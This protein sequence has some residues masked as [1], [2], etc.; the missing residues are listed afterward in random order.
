MT[1]PASPDRQ[2]GV[3]LAYR[4]GLSQLRRE[5]HD[6]TG[7]CITCQ[8]SD[9][10][11]LHQYKGV[12]HCFSCQGKWS[13]FQVAETVL[14]NHEQAKSLMVE[15][16]LF[17]P[18]S[19]DTCAKVAIDPIEAI[20]R[21]K[22]ITPDSLK[23]YGAKAISP[24]KIALPA[25]GANG[26]PSTTFTMSV[27]GGKGLFA[28]GKK[29]GLFFPHRD[30]KVQ[31][32][33]SGEIWH[34]VEGPKDAA[35]LQQLDLL[36]CGLN[37]CHLAAKFAHLFADV[38]VILIPD[39]DHAGEKGS[40]SSASVLRGVGKSV[41]IAVLPAEFK[42]T[43]G[44]DVRDIL[45]RP[46]G[47]DKILEAI[48][49][50]KVPDCWK[51]ICDEDEPPVPTAASVEI[52]LPEGDPIILKVAAA[53][54]RPQR[55][56]TATRGEVEHRDRIN[57]DSSISRDR[58]VKKL[59]DKLSI[60]PSSIF[61]RI[62][63]QLPKLADEID[64]ASHDAETAPEKVVQSQATLAATMAGEW[65]LWHTPASVAYATFA[66]GDHNESWPVK[67]ETFK[68]FLSKKFFD[69]QGKAMNSE[70]VS[71]AV[72]LVQAQAK[73]EG[74]ECPVHVRVAEHNGK[75]YVDL[76]NAQWQVVEISPQGWRIIEDPPVRFRRSRGM[77]PLPTP[78]RGGKVDLL[79][80]FLN[81]DEN[82]WILV[83][84]WL[85]A[86]FRPRG[87]Y[88]ILALFAEQGSGK[89]TIGR[90]LR[91]LID[92][93]AAPLRSEPKDP[94]DLMIAANNSWCLAFDNLSHVPAW[95]SDAICRLSTGGGFATRELYTDQDE[96]IFDSQR[97][98]LL[99][100][101][102]EIATRSDLL[103]RCLIVNLS[104]ISEENRRTVADIIEAFQ[105]E[106]PL[107]LGAL[108]DAVS[109]GLER[110]PSTKLEA[111]PRMADFAQWVTA[112]E[113][114]LGWSEGTF[115]TA[116]QGNRESANDL[117]LEASTI[118]QPLV[119]C[120]EEQGTWSGSTSEL[121]T[122]L[123]N[124]TGGD[125][126]KRQKSWPKNARALSGQL[127]RIAPNLRIKGWIL[128][129]VRTSKKRSWTFR[130]V[131]EPTEFASSQPMFAS[132]I[133]DFASQNGECKAMQPEAKQ[134]KER[135]D[136]PPHD[137]NDA[138]DARFGDV[139]NRDRY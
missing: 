15:L 76:C 112:T 72:N 79:R 96:I 30:G 10:F 124:R 60:D 129:D 98:G 91:D 87:P 108:L 114:G 7:Q 59:A 97:P 48:A 38:T 49:D 136:V 111:L 135:P 5:G 86:A 8:S 128:D 43:D 12:A 19:K 99:T 41:R 39:R 55:L 95:L 102:E 84:S 117:A 92:P 23:A 57:T 122:A 101:I 29:A 125:Q 16:G 42:E 53:A 123:E 69:E 54:G 74:E 46:D 106:R 82:N 131:G 45:R 109:A 63:A 58:F 113:K 77:L 115:M 9:A 90:L 78:E 137:A 2:I 51:P 6:L 26:K 50:A 24:S 105:R 20:A 75:I 4:L 21:Q 110:L 134:C 25:Y 32:P 3:E 119:D 70:A 94:R 11:R 36:A 107:I 13:P 127:R 116:Y 89:S 120:L 35:A 81:V 103:D 1:S 118:A 47:R 67:S 37:T 66:A 52:P 18:N 65:K 22:G 40:K 56:I 73:F 139:W 104:T 138:N 28:K 31:L 64:G 17:E 130:R 62:D 126:V 34:I 14:S 93:N 83:I 61:P 68:Q 133:E 100:S 121:L 27:E 44:E 132:S 71:A 80:R 33:Q 85:M 88:P